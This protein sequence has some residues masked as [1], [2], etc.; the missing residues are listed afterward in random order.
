MRRAGPILVGALLMLQGAGGPTTAALVDRINA[1]SRTPL[2]VLP[3]Q[4][5]IRADMV[6]VPDRYV[7]L[8]SGP[9]PAHVP[10]HWERRVGDREVFAPPTSIVDPG[11]GTIELVPARITTPAESRVGP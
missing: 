7:P 10:S 8:P 4:P 5:P 11:R 9:T 1:A 3:A 6:W 2:P